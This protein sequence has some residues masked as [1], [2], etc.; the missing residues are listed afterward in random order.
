MDGAGSSS[1]PINGSN[2][3]SGVQRRKKEY[4]CSILKIKIKTYD[5]E[6]LT[7]QKTDSYVIDCNKQEAFLK[8]SQS[9]FSFG[10]ANQ[11]SDSNGFSL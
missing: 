9:Y 4:R 11:Y 7:G 10:T 3:R 1:S 8:E 5:E 6:C 2:S